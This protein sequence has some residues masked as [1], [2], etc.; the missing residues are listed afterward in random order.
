MWC[1]GLSVIYATL[2]HNFGGC[3]A[4]VPVNAQTT[5]F[6]TAINNITREGYA[7]QTALGAVGLN[8]M[9]KTAPPFLNCR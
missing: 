6:W 8:H 1:C 9:T 5:V 3:R 7:W 2:H 4:R